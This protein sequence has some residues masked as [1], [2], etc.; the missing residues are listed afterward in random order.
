MSSPGHGRP[1][2]TLVGAFVVAFASS[3]C[4][5]PP[6]A[7]ITVPAPVAGKASDPVAD[8]DPTRESGLVGLDGRP[9]IRDRFDRARETLAEWAKRPQYSRCVG[10]IEES[11]PWLAFLRARVPDPATI[12]LF[13]VHAI[14]NPQHP[15]AGGALREDRRVLARVG[16]AR[17]YDA[18]N[19][20]DIVDF[21]EA[22]RVTLATESDVRA[23]FHAD[24]DPL[25]E[26]VRDG[27]DASRFRL[28]RATSGV[29][30]PQIWQLLTLDADRVP[31]SLEPI[32]SLPSAA[33]NR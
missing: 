3:R 16:D 29:P 21:A 28:H 19:T 10:S 2:L 17:L 30:D 7:P 31:K 22:A 8:P 26:V 24:Y 27:D 33:W 20:G 11:S 5:A 32:D 15:D 18:W 25:M 12:T 4:A 14:V 1:A 6:D 9:P 13:R 23:L